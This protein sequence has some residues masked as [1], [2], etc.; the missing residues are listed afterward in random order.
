MLNPIARW[1]PTLFAF[2]LAACAPTNPLAPEPTLM[3]V[4]RRVIGSIPTDQ[5]PE[6][7]V[8]GVPASATVNQPFMVTVVT[9]DSSSCTA[10]AGAKVEVKGLTAVIIPID[11]KPVA[12]G[13]C[14]DNLAQHPREVELVFEQPGDATIWVIGQNTYTEEPTTNEYSITVTPQ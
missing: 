11:Q 4:T 10:P 1:F 6:L 8:L 9:Y 3:G 14:T 7:E 13:P 2:M 12:S 5:F